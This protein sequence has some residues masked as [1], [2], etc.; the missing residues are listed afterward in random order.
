MT[1]Y[2]VQ[3][4]IDEAVCSILEQS[5]ANLELI[6]VDDGSTDATLERLQAYKNSDRRVSVWSIENQGQTKAL[7]FGLSKVRGPYLARMDAD[8]ISEPHRFERQI[9]RMESDDQLIALGTLRTTIDEDGKII[10]QQKPK[11]QASHDLLS[12]PPRY[13]SL[14]HPSAM[15][16]TNALRRVGGYRPFFRYAQDVDLW[17]RLADQ[18]TL[19]VLPE[20]LLRYRH[21]VRTVSV[22][23]QADQQVYAA[24]ALLAAVARAR[25]LGDPVPEGLAFTGSPQLLPVLEKLGEA[26]PTV[27][28]E[29]WLFTRLA[30]RLGVAQ[31]PPDLFAKAQ[32]LSAPQISDLAK[33]SRLFARLAL[34]R[35]FNGTRGTA[36][37]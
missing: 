28:L 35:S 9:D 19:N 15:I 23:K 6:V 34:W 11:R 21:S 10:K 12:I 8:D 20:R 27:D 1:A 31:M 26:G 37:A 3:D 33:P 18:G 4:T 16:R 17:L 7:N 2:N 25:G 29:L 30:R 36:N 14:V 32:A 5:H 22:E 13:V 24:I